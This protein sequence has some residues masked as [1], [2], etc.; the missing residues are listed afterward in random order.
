MANAI[1]AYGFAGGSTPNGQITQVRTG[2]P[3][4]TEV[5]TTTGSPQA[6]AAAATA[7]GIALIVVDG[8]AYVT[9][10]GNTVATRAWPVPENQLFDIGVT[11]GQ[12]V[13]IWDR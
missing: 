3:S 8:P 11:K 1:I 13:R 12:R 7:D 6:T 9:V 10:D 4:A 2:D 5:I